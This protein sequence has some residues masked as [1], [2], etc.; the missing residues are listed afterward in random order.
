LNLPPFTSFDHLVGELLEVQG[1]VETERL[2]G[3]E[4]D[5]QFELCR[6]HHRQIGRVGALENP[7]DIDSGLAIHL[8]GVGSVAH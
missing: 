4:V 3:L 1:H 8:L 5:C 2:G 6:L 7:A